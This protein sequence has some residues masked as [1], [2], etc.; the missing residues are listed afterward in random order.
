MDTIGGQIERPHERTHQPTFW[1]V[2]SL[3]SLAG[4]SRALHVGFEAPT[5]VSFSPERALDW[6]VA[7]NASKERAFR[8][9][10]VLAHPIGGT[11]DAL[12][13]HHAALFVTPS[14]VAPLE[15]RQRLE[16]AWLPPEV[17]GMKRLARSLVRCD[18]A[19]V[20]FSAAKRADLGPGIIVR[21]ASE[22]VCARTV[23]IWLTSR[24]IQAAAECDAREVDLGPLE[25]DGGC[26]LVPLSSRLTTIRLVHA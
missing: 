8:F 3:L 19:A 14:R 17:R 26:A 21:L 25:V 4:P 9:L 12:Q 6:I 18:D 16:L 5:A 15:V 1:P 23:R 20:S 24:Q 11:A 10:P 7:R 22:K 13:T 2:P